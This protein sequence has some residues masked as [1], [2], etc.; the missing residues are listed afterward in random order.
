[1]S[2][3]TESGGPDFDAIVRAIFTSDEHAGLEDI[4]TDDELEHAAQAL[5]APELLLP[6]VARPY[7]TDPVEPSVDMLLE[8]FHMLLTDDIAANDVN[9]LKALLDKLFSKPAIDLS[10]ADQLLIDQAQLLVSSQGLE[11]VSQGEKVHGQFL[12][13]LP[14]D[15]FAVDD[16][17]LGEVSLVREGEA[18]GLYIA[19]S[20]VAIEDACGGV[21]P[22]GSAR[23]SLSNGL[24]LLKRVVYQD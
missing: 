13:F 17:E 22:L 2:V 19:L 18:Y 20:G 15:L 14:D 21:T 1:M 8:S 5:G 16:Q 6:Q 7:Y 3:G 12:G 11:A 23:V 10:I 9:V 4:I 24:P